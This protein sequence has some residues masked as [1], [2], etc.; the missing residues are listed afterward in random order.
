MRTLLTLACA[1]ALFLGVSHAEDLVVRAGTIHPCGGG[2]A[3]TGGAA[4]WIQDGKI[5]AIGKE[6]PAPL[7]TQEIDYGMGAVIAPGLVATRI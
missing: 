1:A 4:I 7:G 5:K 6:V 2:E 3:L